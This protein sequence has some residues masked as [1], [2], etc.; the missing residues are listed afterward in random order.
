MAIVPPA[1]HAKQA[2]RFGH[3]WLKNHAYLRGFLVVVKIEIIVSEYVT[4]AQNHLTQIIATKI[5][6]SQN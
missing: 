6:L 5:I 3:K 2:K 4:Q 1:K